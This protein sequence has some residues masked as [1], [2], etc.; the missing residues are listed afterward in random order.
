M[1]CP[2]DK[3]SGYDYKKSDILCKIVCKIGLTIFQL[4][5]IF[6]ASVSMAHV[7]L[8]RETFPSFIFFIISSGA[9]YTFHKLEKEM[10]S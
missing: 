5:C 6:T 10:E 9:L 7:I 3:R 4:L 2:H 8:A 1:R